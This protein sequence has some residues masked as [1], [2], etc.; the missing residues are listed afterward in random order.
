MSGFLDDLGVYFDLL[1]SLLLDWLW[2]I[3]HQLLLF[4][5]GEA[6]SS[7]VDFLLR[8]LLDISLLLVIDVSDQEHSLE[9][10]ELRD[11]AL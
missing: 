11:N 1:L 3:K 4:L 8:T 7:S 9:D 2:D 10:S 5:F 6:L